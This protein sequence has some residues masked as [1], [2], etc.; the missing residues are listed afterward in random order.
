MAAKSRWAHPQMAGVLEWAESRAETITTQDE[1]GASGGEVNMPT[2]SA[3]VYDIWMERTGLAL[4]DKRR[5][6][7]GSGLEFWQVLKRDFGASSADAEFSLNSNYL[8][9]R[10]GAR[11]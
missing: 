1:S 8:R 11:T 5:N 9:S 4:Y 10:G 6:A 7:S 3:V 2:V